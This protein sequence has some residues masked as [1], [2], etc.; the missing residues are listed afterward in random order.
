VSTDTLVEALWGSELP[1][2]P[3]NAVQHHVTR[4][5]RALGT[6]TIRLAAD[7]YALDGAVVDAIQFEELL[8]G[9]RGALRAGDARGAAD[10]IADALSLWRG[11]ALLGLPQSSWAT[12]EARRLDALRLDALE[13]RFEAAL[14]LGEHA[15]LVSAIRAALE[16][17]PFRERLWG[18]LMLA[19]YRAG[20]Q[21][22]AL[23]VYQDYRNLL[24]NEMGL[25]PST[26]LQTLEQRVVQQ[27][28]ALAAGAGAA[29]E[30]V[31]PMAPQRSGERSAG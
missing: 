13:E 2:A 10:T 21:T 30:P 7:G 6:D 28:P 25:E 12:A 15:D 26:T 18:Q 19:L 16:E 11:P 20:R 27:D 17:S 3:R 23:H 8:A 4:L 5:R 14:A 24:I 22:E 9:A 29:A 31:T 1:A